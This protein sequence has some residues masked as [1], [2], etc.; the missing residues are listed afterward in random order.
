MTG[1]PFITSNT[2]APADDEARVT[3]RDYVGLPIIVQATDEEFTL[4]TSE[5]ESTALPVRFLSV[6]NDADG[7][8]DT[9]CF[10]KVVRDQ[11]SDGKA[12]LGVIRM[13]E[14]KRYY[15]LEDAT[16]EQVAA[17]TKAWEA[18]SLPF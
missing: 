12:H 9:L 13:A 4:T 14:G 6:E 2:T 7:W 18:N 16:P 5:G 3:L 11:L 15:R 10:W 8:Q 1:A 17:A